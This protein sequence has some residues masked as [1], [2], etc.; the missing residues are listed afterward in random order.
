MD[1]IGDLP[2]YMQV[3]LLRA[4]QEKEIRRIGANF[5]E[6]IDVRIIA[7]TNKKLIDMVNANKFREDL[8]YRLNVV[9][10]TIPPLRERLEDIPLLVKELLFRIS[11]KNGIL[12]EGIDD[13]AIKLLQTYN[14]PGNIREMENV[15][16]RSSNFL[17]KDRIIHK[18]HIY[19]N[20][21]D[22]LHVEFTGK[23]SEIVNR[24]EKTAIKNSLEANGGNKSKTA[25]ALGLSRTSLYEKMRKHNIK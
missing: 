9:S 14:W 13:D 4:L 20:S 23:L 7:A 8:Y 15:I 16:E 2:L 19:L 21:D 18:E 6:K 10:I 3:K 17:D 24:A 5:N 22:N 12:I 11:S 25:R 1:E